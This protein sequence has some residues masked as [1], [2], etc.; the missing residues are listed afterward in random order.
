MNMKQESLTLFP[1]EVISPIKSAASLCIQSLFKRRNKSRWGQKYFHFLSCLLCLTF[2]TFLNKG[3][4]SSRRLIDQ[5]PLAGL[6]L[7][8][9]LWSENRWLG[10][11]IKTHKASAYE[12]SLKC[13]LPDTQFYKYLKLRE[14]NGRPKSFEVRNLVYSR[15]RASLRYCA[16]GNGQDTSKNL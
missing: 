8:L 1:S 4:R 15:V 9:L 16:G 14:N 5:K 13:R 2:V 6:N 10:A 11:E 3:D 12:R 7:H